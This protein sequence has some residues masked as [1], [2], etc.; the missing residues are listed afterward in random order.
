[1]SASTAQTRRKAAWRKFDNASRD[2]RLIRVRQRCKSWRADLGHRVLAIRKE[3]DQQY[4]V[5]QKN[6]SDLLATQR[7]NT[8]YKVPHIHNGNNTE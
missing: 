3:G 1:M 8:I 4:Y 5:P 2:T 7:T 6:R